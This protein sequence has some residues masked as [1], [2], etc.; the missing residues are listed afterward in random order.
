MIQHLRLRIIHDPAFDV[1]VTC[2]MSACMQDIV[3]DRSG[4]LADWIAQRF[5]SSRPPPPPPLR[6]SDESPPQQH[7]PLFE[8][9]HPLPHVLDVEE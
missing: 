5:D 1:A 4:R 2:Q 3:I 9:F 7:Y 6:H 8:Y